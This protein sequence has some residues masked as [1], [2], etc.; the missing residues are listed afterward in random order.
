[1]NNKAVYWFDEK[2]PPVEGW[3][4][5]EPFLK[6][7]LGEG[8]RLSPVYSSRQALYRLVAEGQAF[9]EDRK[10]SNAPASKARMG[11]S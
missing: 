7:T 1:M 2:E 9:A 4:G 5:G 8:L 10:E 11:I 3:E 6:L